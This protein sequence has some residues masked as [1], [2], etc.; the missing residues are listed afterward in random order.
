MAN[1]S[2]LG[3]DATAA[4]MYVISGRR[5]NEAAARETE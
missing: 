3:G 1:G 2:D 4:A 5:K